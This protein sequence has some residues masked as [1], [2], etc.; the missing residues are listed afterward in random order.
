MECE[1][2]RE[3]L[4]AARFSVWISLIAIA[5]AGSELAWHICAS[6]L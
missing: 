2:C 1:R 5:V 3:A 4:Q 6:L